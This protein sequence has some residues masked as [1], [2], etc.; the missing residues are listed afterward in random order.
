MGVSV[1]V[2][3]SGGVNFY[4]GNNEYADGRVAFLPGAAMDWQGEVS[5]V[6]ALAAK[7]TGHPQS[8]L[9]ADRYFLGKGLLFL[10]NNPHQ[11]MSLYL[12]KLGLLLAA[13]ERSNNKKYSLL[14]S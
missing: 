13:G 8:A 5:E 10:K 14:A 6:T 4:I 2:A 9:S 12:R 3:A 11:A 7:E 1:L